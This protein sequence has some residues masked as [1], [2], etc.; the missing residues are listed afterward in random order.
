MINIESHNS[1]NSLWG[2]HSSTLIHGDLTLENIFKKDNSI[3]LIDPLGSTMDINSNGSMKQATSPIFDLGKLFQSLISQYETW[4][5]LDINSISTYIRNFSIEEEKKNISETLNSIS[6]L[7]EFYKQ[8]INGNIL[9]D[10]LFSLAQILIRVC[11][12]RVR[13]KY[14]HS[15]LICLLKANAIMEY[16]QGK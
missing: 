16:L 7:H 10:S 8:Y 3:Y 11:P 2:S 12:Y 6:A 4:A 13:A 5:Y 15:A 14:N 9:D 1:N